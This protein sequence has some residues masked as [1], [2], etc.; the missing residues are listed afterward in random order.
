MPEPTNAQ[1]LAGARALYE[2][3]GYVKP[4]NMAAPNTRT[5]YIS[6]S[7]IVLNA[8]LADVEIGSHHGRD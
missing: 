7:R 1:V 6:R 3:S 4:F 8:A 5:V 2:R